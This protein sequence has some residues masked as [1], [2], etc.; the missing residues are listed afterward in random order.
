MRRAQQVGDDPQEVI[1][2]LARRDRLDSTR[3]TSPLT[4]P[5]GAI[6]VDTSD[7]G[8]EEVVDQVLAMI[9]QKS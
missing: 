1:D 5:S 7:L 2:D 8:F 9:S 3:K 6:V 4:V